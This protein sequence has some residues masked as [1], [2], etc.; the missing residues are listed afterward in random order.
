[1]GPDIAAWEKFKTDSESA[2]LSGALLKAGIVQPY[3]DN[4]MFRIFHKGWIYGSEMSPPEAK[5]VQKKEV[6]SPMVEF[7]DYPGKIGKK[8]IRLYKSVL[9]SI[10]Y[11]EMGKISDYAREFVSDDIGKNL[12]AARILR[13][14]LKEGYRESQKSG[15]RKDRHPP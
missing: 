12:K 13:K 11:L 8:L 2:T 7:P 10:E 4:I 9:W 14:L 15:H 5:R 3:V 1:M 6:R